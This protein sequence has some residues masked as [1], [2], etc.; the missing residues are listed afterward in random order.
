M[1]GRKPAVISQHYITAL[2]NIWWKVKQMFNIIWT[3]CSMY[4]KQLADNWM[5]Q[6]CFEMNKFF[7]GNGNLKIY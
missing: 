1:D 4:E 5:I 2:W 3:I 6:L 7:F